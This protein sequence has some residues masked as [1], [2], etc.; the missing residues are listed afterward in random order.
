MGSLRGEPEC[1]KVTQMEMPNEKL[2]FYSGT[3]P[4]W[5]C[6]VLDLGG[7]HFVEDLHVYI[8]VCDLF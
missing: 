2:A 5:S 3:S 6:V 1:I 8:L 7:R 4:T